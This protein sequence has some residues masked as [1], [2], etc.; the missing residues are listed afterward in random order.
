MSA[1]M[2]KLTH[3]P[4]TIR[5]CLRIHNIKRNMVLGMGYFKRS[6]DDKRDVIYERSLLVIRI[7]I[8]SIA[9]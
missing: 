3:N 4:Q 8:I 1:A 2:S 5:G 9:G 6:H 7:S